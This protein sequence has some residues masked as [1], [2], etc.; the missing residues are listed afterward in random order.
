MGLSEGS[1]CQ[2][3]GLG[4]LLEGSEGL[5]EGPESLPEGPEGLPEGHEGLPGAMGGR[6]DVQNFSPF[7]RILSPVGAVFQEGIGQGR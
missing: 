3:D 7:Y 5:P 6:T 2:P 4:G 1:E